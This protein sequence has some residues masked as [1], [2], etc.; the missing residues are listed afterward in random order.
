M[1]SWTFF[2]ILRHNLVT[3]ENS[4]I[5][6]QE[7]VVEDLDGEILGPDWMPPP[8][9]QEHVQQL[10]SLG[11]LWQLKSCFFC[12]YFAHSCSFSSNLISLSV[13]CNIQVDFTLRNTTSGAKMPQA[14]SSP[15][16]FRGLLLQ[17]SGTSWSSFITWSHFHVNLISAVVCW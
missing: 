16:W 17:C 6:I 1:L 7:Y 11:L 9:P 13:G 8:L 14:L 15:N 3:R 10:K 4:C 5:G 2:E 12:F